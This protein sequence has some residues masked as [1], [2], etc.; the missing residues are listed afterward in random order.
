M[1]QLRPAGCLLIAI[2]L[3]LFVFL[4]FRPLTVDHGDDVGDGF[5]HVVLP[6][7]RPVRGSRVIAFYLVALSI[8]AVLAGL[9]P[10]PSTVYQALVGRL[11]LLALDRPATIALYAARV[12]ATVRLVI[13]ANV[14]AFAAVLRA[15]PGRRAIVALNALLFGALVLGIDATGV[16]TAALAGL[17]VEPAALVS[18]LLVVGVSV[19]VM[20]RLMATTFAVPRPCLIP[21]FGE[22]HRYANA[23]LLAGVL[24]STAVVIG[25]LDVIETVVV[26]DRGASFLTVFVGLPLIYNGL[27]VF[28]LVTLPRSERP[29]SDERPPITVITPA[30]NE[31]AGIAVTLASLDRAAARYGGPVTVLL[32][33]DGSVDQT[34]EVANEAIAAFSSATGHILNLGHQGKSGA[35]NS[36]LNA[37][38]SEI[39]I[40]V[41]AD[42]TIE[43]DALIHLPAWFADPTVGMVG[44]LDL[45]NL[46]LRSW[47]A[48]GRLFECLMAFA[49]ARVALQRLNAINCIPGTFMAFR[50]GPA[51]AVGGFVSGM[52]GEDADLTLL[53]GRL[54]YRVML[55][56]RIRIYEDVPGTLRDF[57][58]QRVR[59]SRAGVQNFSRHSPPRGG[60][61]TPR[62]WFFY[63]RV[64]TVKATAILR[65]LIFATGIELGLL[66]P[67]TRSRAPFVLLLYLIS[68]VPSIVVIS[69][70]AVRNELS[71]HL[72][73]LPLWFPFTLARRVISFE[74]ILTLPT[75]GVPHSMPAVL[76]ALT[77]RHE[78]PGDDRSLS[79]ADHSWLSR[80]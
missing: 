31:E 47:Y 21:Q 13:F 25:A 29:V 48:R 56:T 24:L 39:V 14:F 75:R 70:L 76:A 9:R 50:R 36:G 38:E 77:G 43:E 73:W 55:D 40:R 69:I 52:N 27:L 41:D 1:G 6:R 2:D 71:R 5:S 45:P 78:R 4:S 53:I 19:V 68:G 23:T 58:E 44:A 57:R 28:L 63:V 8:A 74:G 10:G 59:W 64:A 61:G 46:E 65:P 49:F 42:V 60:P 3:A 18:S 80:S 37:A 16:V 35:L 7:P 33:D 32:I 15:T 30:F 22:R 67:A 72:K 12:D 20:M 54:G 62:A 17:P 34:F 11:A 79:E 66:D 26:S 51:Q